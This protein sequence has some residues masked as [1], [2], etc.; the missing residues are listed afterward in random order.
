MKLSPPPSVGEPAP[1]ARA[2]RKGIYRESRHPYPAEWILG[3][4]VIRLKLSMVMGGVIALLLITPIAYS[5]W[6]TPIAGEELTVKLVV[7]EPLAAPNVT[8]P[9]ILGVSVDWTDNANGL[10]ND[11]SG[12][13]NPAAVSQLIHLDP[14]HL[15]FPATRLSQAYEWEKGVGNKGEREYNPSHGPKPQQS[16]FGTDEFL[17]L[18]DHVGSKAVM[19]VNSNTGS[20]FSASDWVSYCND[21]PSTR[22]GHD[23]AS[24]GYSTPYG[25]KDW[26][27]GYE[28]Y[29]P[30]YWEGVSNSDN[31]AGTLYGQQVRNFSMA[32]KTIDPSIKIGAWMVLHPDQEELSADESWNLNFLN[33]AGGRF[34][35][36]GDNKYFFDYVL[37]KVNLPNIEH[38]LNFPDLYAYAYA[39]TL[40]GMRNDL[41]QLRGLLATHPRED[42]DIPLAVAGFQPDFG[43]EGWNTQAPAYAASGL[44][45]ADLAMQLISLS[46][47]D[48]KQSVR[49][50]CYSELNTPTYSSLMI[51]PSFDPA[52]IETW[53]QSPNY[54]AFE[55]AKGLQGGKPLTVTQL[56]GPS[57]DIAAEREVSAILNVPFVSAIATG[58]IAEGT[59]HILLVNRDLHQS[60]K[61][62]INVEM[63]GLSAA[64]RLSVRHLQFE[65]LL[66]TN[67]AGEDVTAPLP[68]LGSKR[69]VDPNDFTI[70][71][72]RAG[73]VLVT[74]ETQGVT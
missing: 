42:G 47:E 33:E 1:G 19:V 22:R 68:T 8:V 39:Q 74:L 40:M 60:I 14:S 25:I 20:A 28:P 55:L 6:I 27:I 62:R 24:N 52:N 70:T 16:L 5:S 64:P 23:R 48:G 36:A 49:Y 44:I 58:D 71:L 73:V 65:S 3:R 15:R 37:V 2:F 45:T 4:L 69:I 9:E 53:G 46:L 32:M 26:E 12:L 51:N 54:L 50:A 43:D 11:L 56:E 38:L 29:L 30:K 61:C 31:P 72:K 7:I 10:Y 59:V 57:Y 66:S 34:N 13:L 21:G 63:T 41:A 67:L 17:K 35:L 18:V